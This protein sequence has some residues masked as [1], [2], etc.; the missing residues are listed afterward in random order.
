MVKGIFTLF[1]LNHAKASN[2]MS[3]GMGLRLEAKTIKSFKLAMQ[4]FLPHYINVD[5]NL[6]KSYSYTFNLLGG[7]LPYTVT[8]TDIKYD[9]GTFDFK[10]IWVSL[11]HDEG[12]SPVMKFDFPSLE[13]WSVHAN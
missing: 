2:P 1:M 6:P 12:F 9:T 10:D 7:V 4:E 11:E 8:W 13:K 5:A 3:P